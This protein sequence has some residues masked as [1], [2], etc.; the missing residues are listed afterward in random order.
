[1]MFLWTEHHFHFF[2]HRDSKLVACN[3]CCMATELLYL[4]LVG[5]NECIL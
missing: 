3:V 2:V 4:M 5:K 1:M